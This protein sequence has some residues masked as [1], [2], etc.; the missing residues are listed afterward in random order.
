MQDKSNIQLK[1]HTSEET[2]AHFLFITATV[3]EAQQDKLESTL[4][5]VLKRI[6]F[7]CVF[8]KSHFNAGNFSVLLD[9]SHFIHL[10]IKLCSFFGY[11]HGV[12]YT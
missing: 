9:S 2:E 12:N 8:K 11:V 5:V 4:T 10:F 3:Y 6:L 1:T 7:V